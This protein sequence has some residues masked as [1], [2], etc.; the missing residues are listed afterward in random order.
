ML[1]LIEAEREGEQIDRSL[2]KN[3]LGIYQE[4]GG[5]QQGCRIAACGAS[6]APPAACSALLSAVRPSL[7]F[8]PFALRRS[9]WAAWSATSATLR[10][11]C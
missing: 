6:A 10:S 4:V 2:L 3:V 5:G 11:R 1:K 8:A 9:A 7:P